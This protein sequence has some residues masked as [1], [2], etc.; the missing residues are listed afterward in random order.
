MRLQS[1]FPAMLVLPLSSIGYAWI[2]Q[3]HQPISAICVM[4]FMAGVSGALVSPFLDYL[5][6]C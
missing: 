5:A 2:C 6:N 3:T 4:L 1:T